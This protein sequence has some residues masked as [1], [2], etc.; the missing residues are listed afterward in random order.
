MELYGHLI[1][2]VIGNVEKVNKMNIDLAV[3][4]ERVYAAI[5]REKEIAANLDASIPKQ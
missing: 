2:N 5:Q 1:S 4:L 3:E